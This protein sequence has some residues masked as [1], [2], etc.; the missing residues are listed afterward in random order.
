MKLTALNTAIQNYFTEAGHNSLTPVQEICIEKL[1]QKKS[2][3]AQAP[4]G[5]GKTLAYAIP[6]MQLAKDYELASKIETVAS[7]TVIILTPTRE[8]ASQVYQNLKKISHHIKLRVRLMTAG[9]SSE[10]ILKTKRE[11]FEVVVGTPQRIKT[12]TYKKELNL[13]NLKMLVL[14]EADQ[15]LDMGFQKD[16]KFILDHSNYPDLQ[17][18]LFTATINPDLDNFVSGLFTATNFEK[19]ELSGS[20][21]V[22]IKMTTFNVMVRPEEKLPLLKAFIEKTAKGRGI[23]FANQ[24]NQVDEIYKFLKEKMPKMK[25][26]KLHGELTAIERENVFKAFK[27]KKIHI[28]VSSDIAARGVDVPDLIW[29]LNYNLPKTS[30]YYLHRIGRVARGEAKQGLIYNMVTI[31]DGKWVRMI[32]ESIK[33][34]TLLPIEPIFV[35]GLEI[36]REKFNPHQKKRLDAKA[37]KNQRR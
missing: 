14:D 31:K 34:Q 6:A 3:L 32:N 21:K 17:I 9:Q 30:I 16:L 12:A 28:L 25:V 13:S 11:T 24:K 36:K 1:L 23:I 33:T 7:P 8:L 35:K 27:E 19:I 26:E 10:R 5:T 15:L 20:Q 22:S 18:S 29:V 2:I 37:K 4:T